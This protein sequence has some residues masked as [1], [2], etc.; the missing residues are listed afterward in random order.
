MGWLKSISAFIVV[1]LVVIVTVLLIAGVAIVLP[2]VILIAFAW[3]IAAIVKH[4]H[5][6]SKQNKGDD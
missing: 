5:D 6:I 2:L 4:D 1:I 3:F